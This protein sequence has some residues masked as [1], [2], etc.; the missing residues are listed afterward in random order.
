M[1]KVLITGTS[2]GIGFATALAVARAG[3]IVY[4]TLRK[5]EAGGA[6]RE[7]AQNEGLPISIVTMDVD[8]QESVDSGYVRHSRRSRMYRRPGEQRGHRARRVNRS[9]PVQ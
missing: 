9:T 8:S 7:A 2:R 3:H 1:A 6:L 4:A 5:P